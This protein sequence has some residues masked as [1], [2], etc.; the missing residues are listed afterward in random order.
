MIFTRQADDLP[1]GVR[2]FVIHDENDDYTIF[3]NDRLGRDVNLKTLDHELEHI[4]SNDFYA[5]DEADYIETKRHG[6]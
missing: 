5:T 1:F 2:G 4:E 3:L 6:E